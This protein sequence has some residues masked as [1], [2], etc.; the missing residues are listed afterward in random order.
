MA[1]Q[2]DFDEIELTESELA[3][4]R[5]EQIEA[6]KN[7]NVK[8]DFGQALAGLRGDIMFKD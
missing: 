4:R 8:Y 5:Q 6:W 7:R 3:R 2:L 1:K